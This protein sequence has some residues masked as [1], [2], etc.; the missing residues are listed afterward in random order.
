MNG[1]PVNLASARLRGASLR[2]ATL[3][4]ANLSG[5]DL[6]GADLTDGRLDGANLTNA[7]LSHALLNRTDFAGA[8]LVGA[9]LEGTNLALACNLTQDQIMESLGDAF[10]LLPHHLEPPVS[11][12]EASAAEP[13]LDDGRSTPCAGRRV[14][15]PGRH[16]V[17]AGRRLWRPQR[18][19]SNRSGGALQNVARLAHDVLLDLLLGQPRRGAKREDG[20]RQYLASVIVLVPELDIGAI[21]LPVIF[22]VD[23]FEGHGGSLD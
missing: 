16:N 21:G 19:K 11:W 20:D 22:R 10:T 6:S 13:Q 18:R 3:S 4:G 2:F 1:G 9:R 12:T 5:A 15:R 7:D 8:R 23:E 17:L 14:P